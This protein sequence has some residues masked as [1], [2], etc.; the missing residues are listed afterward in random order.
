MDKK[1]IKRW[2]ISS[3]LSFLTGFAIVFVNQIDSLTL[4]SFK[5][6][7]LIGLLFLSVRAGLK[8]ILEL[9]LINQNKN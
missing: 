9:Y 1:N 5:D 4:D 7:T 6:G 8:G 2:I 3:S